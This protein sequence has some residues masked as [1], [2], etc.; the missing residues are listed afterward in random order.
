MWVD[1]VG[2]KRGRV[3]APRVDVGGPAAER[4]LIEHVEMMVLGHQLTESLNVAPI[5]GVDKADDCRNGGQ[6]FLAH[7]SASCPRAGV[8]PRGR[9]NRCNALRC[10][11]TCIPYRRCRAIPVRRHRGVRDRADQRVAAGV[12][13]V[14]GSGCIRR[15][16]R[17]LAFR[18][19]RW[20]VDAPNR[21]R[22]H[23]KGAGLRRLVR[24]VL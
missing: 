1:D 23:P 24:S 10:P 17:R 4:R 14:R 6:R 18:R 7:G 19:S 9:A 5:D 12:W 22:S 3:A 11:R 20:R 15:R 16:S 13:W 8:L 21:R 2:G